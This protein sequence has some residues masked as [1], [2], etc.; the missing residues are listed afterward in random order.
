MLI[1]GGSPSGVFNT[2]LDVWALPLAAEPTW[3]PLATNAEPNFLLVGATYGPMHDAIFAG[4]LVEVLTTAESDNCANEGQLWMLSLETLEWRRVEAEG[5]GPAPPY[6][7]D[8]IVSSTRGGV[9][10]DTSFDAAATPWLFDPST[11]KCPN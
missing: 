7:S 3:T 1:V 2:D 8:F 10:F 4:G 11:L 5:A 6:A 9:R